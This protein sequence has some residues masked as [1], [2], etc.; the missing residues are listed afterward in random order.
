MSDAVRDDALQTPGRGR[1]GVKM[2]DIVDYALPLGILGKLAHT[3]FVRKKLVGIFEHRF[4][5]LEKKFSQ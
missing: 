2:I 5:I 1:G 3:I 4:Q